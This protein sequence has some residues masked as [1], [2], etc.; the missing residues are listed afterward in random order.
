MQMEEERRKKK[1]NI[2][3]F[4]NDFNKNGKTTI[5][6]VFTNHNRIRKIQ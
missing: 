2:F 1:N 6:N 5:V 3:P 4:K